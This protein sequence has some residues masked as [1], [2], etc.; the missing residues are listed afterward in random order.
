MY[1]M[2]DQTGQPVYG[3]LGTD[4]PVQFKA[5]G[6]YTMPWGTN[7]GAVYYAMSGTPVTRQVNMVSSFP[8]QYLGRLSDGRLPMFS[9]LDLN[10]QHAFRI[11]GARRVEVSLNVL[12]LLDQ[13]TAVNRFAPETRLRNIA[14]S[15]PTSSTGSMSSSS[16]PSRASRSSCSKSG[17][18]SL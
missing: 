15:M 11:G 7:V 13:D 6:F 18:G 12:N 2:F 17:P 8:V 1:M 3:V 4:R 10:L 5:N 9:Q 16:S 14:I